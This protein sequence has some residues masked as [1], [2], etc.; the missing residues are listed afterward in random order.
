MKDYIKELEERC[1]GKRQSKRSAN[2]NNRTNCEIFYEK[3]TDAFGGMS[4][5]DVRNLM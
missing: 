1:K 5:D 2:A 3:F 4:V